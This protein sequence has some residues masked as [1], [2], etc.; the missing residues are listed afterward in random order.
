[1][2]Y[3]EYFGLQSAFTKIIMEAVIIYFGYD[4]IFSSVS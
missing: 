1:M 2:E 4:I 3:Q